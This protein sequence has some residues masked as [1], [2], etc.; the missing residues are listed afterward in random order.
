MEEIKAKF[1]IGQS[2]KV[3]HAHIHKKLIGESGIIKRV[4]ENK[5]RADTS[6]SAFSYN[7]VFNIEGEDQ[8]I[9]FNEVKLSE[10]DFAKAVWLRLV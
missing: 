1:S 10:D 8:D 2:V 3:I 6:R 9:T 4:Y 5:H 7:I